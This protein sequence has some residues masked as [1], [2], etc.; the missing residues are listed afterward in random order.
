MTSL[1]AP[2]LRAIAEVGFEARSGHESIQHYQHEAFWLLALEKERRSAALQAHF[3]GRR[4]RRWYV[5][6]LYRHCETVLG[7]EVVEILPSDYFHASSALSCEQKASELRGC[8][9]LVSNNDVASAAQGFAGFSELY[10]VATSTV[11]VGWDFDNHHWMS[12]SPLFAAHCDLYV[13]THPENLY[14]LSRFNPNLSAVVPAGT[15]Q[16]SRQLLVSHE[17]RIVSERRS[18]LPLGMHIRY[19]QFSRRNEIVDRLSAR[20]PT[21]GWSTAEFHARSERDRL[22]EWVGFKSHW[23]VPVLNDISLRV[24]DALVTGG[25]PIVPRALRHCPGIA[26]IPEEFI[27]FYDNADIE[28]PEPV[29]DRANRAFDDGGDDGVRARHR[30][31]V[32]HH[33]VDERLARIRSAT[34]RSFGVR[35]SD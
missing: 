21:I 30:Y 10:A 24:Y 22:F 2:I 17:E 31:G 19:P 23:V 20:I 11:F 6:H 33:H 26:E 8:V 29:V 1:F 34:S 12:L 4:P 9:V 25:V 3:A 13:P 35:A 14:A 5:S 15:I 32:A 16:W 27:I 28:N 18:E 7:D